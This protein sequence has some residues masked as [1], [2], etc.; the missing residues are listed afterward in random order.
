MHDACDFCAQ[1]T[2]RTAA[3]LTT[4]AQCPN[5][6]AYTMQSRTCKY[7][8]GA[9]VYSSSSSP[10]A[11]P[12]T[13]CNALTPTS[14]RRP[15]P[16]T[17]RS[18]GQAVHLAVLRCPAHARSHGGGKCAPELLR[19]MSSSARGGACRRADG[20]RRGPQRSATADSVDLSTC[21]RVRAR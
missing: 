13:R 3:S 20:R 16:R 19:T 18:S 7:C 10:Q 17:A 14:A 15:R 6:A 2:L 8:V 1:D 12:D 4:R 9:A 21:S 11:T 5:V